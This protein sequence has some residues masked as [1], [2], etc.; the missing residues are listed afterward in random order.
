MSVK[1]FDIIVIT[2]PT[3][4]GKTRLAALV[5]ARLG[6]EVISADSR[7]VYRGMDIGTGKD[8][9]DYLVNGR[10]VPCH[11]VDIVDAG[12][13]YNVFEYQRDFLKVYESMCSWGL[14]P[15][16]CG[17][18]GMYVD[19][20]VSGYR[21]IQVPVN[22]PLRQKLEGK[23]LHELT[24]ILSDYKHLHNKTDVDTVKRAVRA[25]EIEEYYTTENVPDTLLPDINPLIIG[26]M[27]DRDTRR[28]RISR[29]LRERLEGGM[30]EEVRRLLDS[31][32]HPDDLIYY[33][34]EYKYV[35]LFIL[36]TMT[37]SE[38]FSKLETE[39]HRFAKRQMTW[40]RGMERRGI[41][42]CWIDGALSETEKV[43]TVIKMLGT[44]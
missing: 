28:E 4:T 37:Y 6:S 12:Y 25:I 24:G 19:S 41:K 32:I 15:V 13:R 16:V 26:I 30:V 43:G 7:Q 22:E 27:F 23:D 44:R 2:G 8:M 31:G 29:R 5:A 3:A 10:E 42:I 36:G 9:S 34:L 33:G 20:I 1:S 11:L 40:F 17:G 38:M 18:S 21:L 14:L 39:I 35:T